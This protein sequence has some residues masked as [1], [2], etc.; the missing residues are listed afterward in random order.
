MPL[1]YLQVWIGTKPPESLRDNVTQLLST[2]DF[3]GG[4]TYTLIGTE[5]FISSEDVNFIQIEEYLSLYPEL[6]KIISKAEYANYLTDAQIRGIESSFIRFHYMSINPNV[7]YLDLDVK[8]TSLPYF[9]S[10]KTYFAYFGDPMYES[11]LLEV[12][13]VEEYYDGLGID[14]S[15]LKSFTTRVKNKLRPNSC[16]D[17][18]MIYNGSSVS[19]FS[20]FIEH[21]RGFCHR[22][23]DDSYVIPF[24]ILDRLANTRFKDR[25]EVIPSEHFDHQ[26]FTVS[27]R[28]S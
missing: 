11:E 17:I 23:Y 19:M 2:I 13:K 21:A 9:D 1:N 7:L 8:I 22:G 12:Q 5:N 3:K 16:F 24:S 18:F 27:G 20:E 26:S 14:T 28:I 15:L 4:D 6:N 25:I 10:N